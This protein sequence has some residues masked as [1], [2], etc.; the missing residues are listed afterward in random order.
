[1][2]HKLTHLTIGTLILLGLFAIFYEPIIARANPDAFC[3]DA[4]GSAT[5]TLSYMRPGLGT[6][7]LTAS[8]CGGIFSPIKSLHVQF[9][10]TASTTAPLLDARCEYAKQ[11][12]SDWY[13]LNSNITD[14][15]LSATS[16]LAG[17]FTGFRFNLATSSEE[18]I[19]SG[20]DARLHR[21]F[22]C[23][24]LEKNVRVVFTMPRGGGE[25][26]IWAEVNG[27]SEITE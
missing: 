18:S 5:T 24:A 4:T 8:K 13:P 11:N 16:T 26:S 20:T 9:Q 17:R 21:S 1:M 23:P 12:S 25:G 22:T 2:T 10:F 15:V 14:P 7:T 27:K 19:G 6:T 3:N